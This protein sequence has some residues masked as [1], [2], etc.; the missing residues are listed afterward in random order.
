MLLGLALKEG[1]VAHGVG[2]FALGVILGVCRAAAL[3]LAR[4]DLDELALV[5]E[6]HGLAVCPRSKAT[7]DQMRRQ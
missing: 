4:V 3:G 6:A 2:A 7:T 5:V 1:H